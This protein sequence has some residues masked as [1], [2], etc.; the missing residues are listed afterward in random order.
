MPP[1]RVLVI[2]RDAARSEALASL[3]RTAGHAASIEPDA[4]V[5]AAALAGSPDMPAPDFELIVLDLS[6]PGLDLSLLRA[7]LAAGGAVPPDGLAAAERRH[8]ARVLE[9]TGG[10]RR[11]AAIVL[12]ISRS[13][14]L[15]KIRKYGLD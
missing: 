3:L 11:R 12:G 4:G 5:A 13:T 2:H 10:N 15:N 7:A 8:I 14:L 1:D 9:H 6:L